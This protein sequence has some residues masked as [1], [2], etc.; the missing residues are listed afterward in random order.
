MK[1]AHFEVYGPYGGNY[2]A[3]SL[4][5]YDGRGGAF[6]FSYKTLVVFNSRETGLVVRRND[7]GPTTGKHLNAI[8]REQSRRV[9]SEEFYRRYAE[10]F[11][12]EE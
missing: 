4:V 2:G 12:G 3:N 7:W 8:C 6:Y 9:G 11:G 10:A 1:T 5:F